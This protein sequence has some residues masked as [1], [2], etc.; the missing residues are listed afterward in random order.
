MLYGTNH[1]DLRKSK[2]KKDQL[3]EEQ[4]M[5]LIRLVEGL[6]MANPFLDATIFED[7]FIEGAN[8]QVFAGN[9]PLI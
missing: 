8:I 4:A 2:G 7:S 9:L 5:Q 6:S 1:A 3:G